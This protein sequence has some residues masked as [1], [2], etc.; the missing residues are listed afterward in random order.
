M[1]TAPTP[2]GSKKRKKQR[3]GL[4]ITLDGDTRVLYMADLGPNDDMLS[5]K[6]T[7]M[8]VSSFVGEDNFALDSVAILWWMACRKNGQPRLKFR[9]V[10]KS[11]PSYA[12]LAEMSEAG[13]F[14]IDSIEDGDDD[15]GED[16]PLSSAA[17]S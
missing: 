12:Q 9:E 3:T 15:E 6:E 7:T 10:L 5:R 13:T 11:F 16:H 4:R 17:D 14:S 1:A 2:G 8:P